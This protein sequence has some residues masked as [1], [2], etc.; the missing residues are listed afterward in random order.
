MA[1]A[2]LQAIATAAG[3]IVTAFRKRP[4]TMQRRH[5]SVVHFIDWISGG[6]LRLTTTTCTKL[7]RLWNRSRHAGTQQTLN[8][9]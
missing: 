3:L 7:R 4:N 6:L 2:F 9:Y 5:F 1:A 8:P